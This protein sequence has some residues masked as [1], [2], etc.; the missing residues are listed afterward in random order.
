MALPVLAVELPPP[1]RL[2]SETG[3]PAE[4]VE[5][6]EPHAS[7]PGHELRVGYRGFGM[8]GLLDRLFGERWK[9]P[10]T[11]VVFFAQDGYRSSTDSGRFLAGAAWLAF[12]RADG[13]PFAVDNP[14]QHQ[15]GVA[16]GPYYLIWDNLHDPLARAQGAYGWPYQ[17]VRIDLATPADYAAARPSDADPA[18]SEGFGQAKK[19]CLTCH[20]IAGIGGEKLPGDLREIS[21]P[22]SD[23]ALK[24]W[25]IEPQKMRPGTTMPP[26][27]PLVPEIERNRIA[28]LIIHYLRAKPASAITTP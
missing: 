14:S 22:L 19:Y 7:S 11:E 1:D 4:T 9:A 21:R 18:A 27:A 25:I 17:V 10:G 6:I 12:G 5:V 26:L 13:K 20:R 24:S 15:S 16:L 28:D 23:Q 3:V 2:E 8:A